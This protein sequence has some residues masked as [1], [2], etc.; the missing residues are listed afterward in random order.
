[1]GYITNIILSTHSFLEEAKHTPLPFEG[2]KS[3]ISNVDL[4]D[5]FDTEVQ[6][7]EIILADYLS[8]IGLENSV[9]EDILS[10]DIDTISTFAKAYCDNYTL[11]D[12]EKIASDFEK[13]YDYTVMDSLY[14]HPCESGYRKKRV[15]RNG[16]MEWICERLPFRRVILT[17]KQKQALR[18]AR[19]KSNTIKAKRSRKKSVKIGNRKGLYE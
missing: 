14:P 7:D 17:S 18:R 11:D 3:L 1:M 2:L 13:Q 12:I 19:V 4:D 5:V 9:I 15:I 6:Q 10:D 16:K 8:Y